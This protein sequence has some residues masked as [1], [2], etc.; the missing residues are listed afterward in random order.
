MAVIMVKWE[1]VKNRRE[2]KISDEFWSQLVEKV[3]EAEM[4]N[5]IAVDPNKLVL[6][7]TDEMVDWISEHCDNKDFKDKFCNRRTILGTV[8]TDIVVVERIFVSNGYSAPIHSI[9]E[10]TVI[11]Y[12]KGGEWSSAWNQ[13]FSFDTYEVKM[14]DKCKLRIPLVKENMCTVEESFE[15]K[16]ERHY[17]KKIA[18]AWV[19]IIAENKQFLAQH[20]FVDEWELRSWED[21]KISDEELYKER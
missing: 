13:M 14:T 18:W 2:Y 3:E 7:N 6:H 11:L 10:D 12:K 8:L 15:H 1:S 19:D 20:L 5:R 17:G 9:N 16:D 21:Y 4:C